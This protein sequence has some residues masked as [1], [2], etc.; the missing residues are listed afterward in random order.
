MNKK[1]FYIKNVQTWVNLRSV[2][3][4]YRATN[5]WT[6]RT[7]SGMEFPL[8]DEEYWEITD[9]IRAPFEPPF[10]KPEVKKEGE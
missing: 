8:A 5:G 3:A 10:H 7:N 6:I 4:I 9:V 2:E 1:F